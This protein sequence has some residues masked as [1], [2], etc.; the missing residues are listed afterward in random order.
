MIKRTVS[1]GITI[2]LIIT[3]F[4]GVVFAAETSIYTKTEMEALLRKKLHIDDD[5]KLSQVNLFTRDLQRKQ[6]WNLEFEKEKERIFVTAAADTGEIINYHQWKDS[7][8][9]KAIA[10]LPDEARGKAV[11]F[12]QSLEAERFKETEEIT[13]EAPSMIVYNMERGFYQG[14]N[15][16]FLFIRKLEE[17][18]F[19][20]NYFRVQVSGIDGSITDYEMKWDDATYNNKKNLIAKEKARKAFEEEDRFIL[21]YV[22]LYSNN[23]D[24][25]SKPFLTPVYL[26]VPKESDLI[27]AVDGRLLKIE[28]I[29]SQGYGLRT[30]IS[31]DSAM[32]EMGAA[33]GQPEVIPEEGV[34]SKEKAEKI[35]SETLGKELDMKELK[36]QSSYYSQYHYGRKGKF[37][38]IYWLDEKTDRRLHATLDGEKGEVVSISYS[39]YPEKVQPFQSE[40]L[41]MMKENSIDE[42]KIKE[43]VHE[44]IKVLFPH[45]QAEELQ[46]EAKKLDEDSLISITSSR[47]IDGIPYEENYL[48]ITYDG[49]KNKIVELDYRWYE[50]EVQSF[51]KV[52]D[53]EMI[54]K[55][56]YDAVGFEKYLIQLKDEAA[57]KK[58][59]LDLPLKELAPIYTLKTFHFMYIDA[60]NGKFLNYNG[61]EYVKEESLLADFKDIENHSYGNQIILLNRMGILKEASEFFRPNDELLRKDAIKWI[62]EMT[63]RNRVYPDAKV[64][65]FKDVDKEDPYYSYIQA[66]IANEIIEKNDDYFR[67]DETVTKI[68]VTQ[69]ILNALEQKE[70]A[71][72]T[73][74]FQIPYT[75]TEEIDI[76]DTGYVALAKYYN[77]FGDKETTGAFNPNK[78]FSRGEFASIIYHLIKNKW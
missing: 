75:D 49:N 44:K 46:L 29:Y 19:P 60:L 42:V 47:Y 5:M 41:E 34:I 33:Y 48:K 58:D 64:I 65:A 9:G 16:H 77:I 51:S 59:R 1:I 43:K 72:F 11:A 73:E 8:Y 12:I 57:Y 69:W 30:G 45:I 37:W 22:A 21:K 25:R 38:E 56:F 6:M 50:V 15:Y 36:V 10:V 68:E 14:E 66:A 26:Y 40:E 24:E 74:I 31:M 27:H 3:M 13:V 28:E 23:K 53:K 20:N 55:K 18:F 61:E 62:V 67:P 32:K 71:Q 4:Q 78:V 7:N 76:E 52:L 17:E 70:L 63:G 39:E 54:S 35:V 2:L